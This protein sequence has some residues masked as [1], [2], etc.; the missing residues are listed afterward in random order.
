[1]PHYDAF[2][3]V[4]T[5]FLVIAGS[6]GKEPFR[7]LNSILIQGHESGQIRPIGQMSSFFEVD[8]VLV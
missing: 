2:V 1:M 8:N 7:F 5:E 6:N 4:T 3:K